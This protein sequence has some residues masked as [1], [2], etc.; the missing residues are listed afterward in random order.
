[1]INIKNMAIYVAITPRVGLLTILITI[2]NSFIIG[3]SDVFEINA[4]SYGGQNYSTENALA[5]IKSI[6]DYILDT[7][8]II[9]D[10]IMRQIPNCLSNSQRVQEIHYKQVINEKDGKQY[11]NYMSFFID[12]PN[13]ITDLP[14]EIKVYPLI[15]KP[16]GEIFSCD[17]KFDKIFIRKSGTD[18]E[19]VGVAKLKNGTDS[20]E[21]YRVYSVEPCQPIEYIL[22][23]ENFRDNYKSQILHMNFFAMDGTMHLIKEDASKDDN[24]EE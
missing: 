3:D 22:Y 18:E 23:I 24:S 17:F 14:D 13:D 5:K 12:V 15:V 6:H 11:I 9:L 1:M 19:V 10:E 20:N 8:E 4:F 21:F 7:V 2:K 16:N